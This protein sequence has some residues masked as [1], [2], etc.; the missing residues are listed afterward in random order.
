MTIRPWIWAVSATAAVGLLP[1]CKP[2]ADGGGTLK[3]T[4][5]WARATAPGQEVGAVYLIVRNGT[6]AEDRLVGG[7]TSAARSVE[8]HAMRMDGTIMRMRRQDGLDIPAGGSAELGP[9]GTHLMLVGL[10]APLKAGAEIPLSLDFSGA[11]RKQVRVRV[12][13]I[14]ATGPRDDADE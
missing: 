10:K 12:R 8:I 5:A 2:A 9:G 13:P 14:G 6:S 11:G 4:D 7:S 3:A 1:A